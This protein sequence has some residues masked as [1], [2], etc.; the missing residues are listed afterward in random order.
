MDKKIIIIIAII[1]VVAILVGMLALNPIHV[2]EETQIN[3]SSNSTLKNGDSVKFQLTDSKGNPLSGQAVGISLSDGKTQNNYSITTDS[4]GHG[5]LVLDGMASGNYTVIV[6]YNGTDQ[7]NPSKTVQQLKIGDVSSSSGNSTQQE[8]I[9]YQEPASSSDRNS[10]YSQETPT[11]SS[12]DNSVS[13]D[14]K[15]NLY[16]DSDG[17]VVDPDGHHGMGVGE[18]YD[19]LVQQAKEVDEKGLN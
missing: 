13:Y 1:A 19:D 7:Y 9:T 14:S 17:V 8:N 10:S 15:L 4:G 11:T 6:S 3:F 18:K 5:S 16:Y 12:S 2:K